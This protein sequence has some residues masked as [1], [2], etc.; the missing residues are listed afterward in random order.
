LY[1]NGGG[2]RGDSLSFTFDAEYLFGGTYLDKIKFGGRYESRTAEEFTRTQDS[3]IANTSLAQ[4]IELLADNGASG[5]GSGV[6]YKVDDYL[7][8]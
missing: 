6:V 5:D 1:D 2:N 3:G 4:L 8:G 7:D